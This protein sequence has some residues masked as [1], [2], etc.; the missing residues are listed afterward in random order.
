MG[1]FSI[2]LGDVAVFLSLLVAFIYLISFVRNNKAYKLFA[3]YLIL[4]S[5]VQFGA[6]YTG[7]G[8]LHKPNLHFSHFYYIIQFIFLS[9]FFWELLKQKTIL[10]VAGLVF[11]FL[12]YQYID[13]PS[14]FYRYNALGM[15]LT[16]T[17]LVLYAIFY[18]FKSLTGQ[19]EFLIVTV[20]L[21]IYLLSS[22]L[23][24]ASGNLL[25]EV[26]KETHLILINTNR[27]LYL[28]FQVLLIIEW[29]KNYRI[30]LQKAP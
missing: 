22:T 15:A 19:G 5:I 23:I 2:V 28:L 9:A 1:K 16:H 30:P 18:L 4:I 3:A 24:F 25:Y 17:I 20:G 14:I 29:F 13:D 7:R 10:W 27:I 11:L 6:Y 21:F 8:W 26:S 12:S